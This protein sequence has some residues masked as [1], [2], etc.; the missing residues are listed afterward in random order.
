[1][2][3][4]GTAQQAIIEVIPIICI[5]RELNLPVI[6]VPS[7]LLNIPAEIRPHTALTP[8]RDI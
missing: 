2:I 7:V 6:S 5:S 1:M 8:C 4:V 3:K